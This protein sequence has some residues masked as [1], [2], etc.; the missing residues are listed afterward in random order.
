MVPM[1]IILVRNEGEGKFTKNLYMKR[2]ES[3]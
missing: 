2:L 3:K 1:E